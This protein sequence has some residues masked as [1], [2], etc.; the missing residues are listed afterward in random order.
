MRE[1]LHSPLRQWRGIPPVAAEAAT[2]AAREAGDMSKGTSCR[3]YLAL[4]AAAR[5]QLAAS[6]TVLPFLCDDVFGT[7]DDAGTTA[8]L[9]LMRETGMTG[10]AIS[11]THDAHVVTLARRLFGDEVRIQSLEEP[12]GDTGDAGPEAGESPQRARA[13]K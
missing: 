3:L 1:V 8:A 9:G 6:W 12:G 2:G 4:G 5:E 7:V 10:Q 11:L 13:G